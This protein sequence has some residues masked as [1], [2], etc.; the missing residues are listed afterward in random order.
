MGTDEQAASR[1]ILVV[2]TEAVVGEGIGEVLAPRLRGGGREAFVVA[3]AI[4]G[5][6]FEH[7]M[8]SVDDARAEAQR[9]LDESLGALRDEGFEV[10]GAVGDS[11]PVLAIQ[12]ALV[13]FAADEIVIVTRPEDE[14]RWLEA[15]LFE[16][17][18]IQFEQEV[19]H[20]ALAREDGDRA[21]VEDVERAAPGFHEP[22]DREIE[23]ES[24]NLPK[25][26]A[27]DIAG[28]TVAVV[29]SILLVILAGTC[30]P[31]EVQRT[32]GVEGQGTDGGCVA[33]WIIA[34]I[35]VLINLAHIVALFLFQ[36]VRYRGF[37][38]R[39]FAR[40]SL[41]GTPLALAIALLIRIF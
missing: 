14:A 13:T 33:V 20:V 24:R 16:R 17:A 4:I 1:R 10:G 5:S 37:W 11:D 25:L 31:H 30:D 3:P 8:G 2:A 22:P 9:R 23:T 18:R 32:G 41:Y 28:I 36:A 12:D 26:S 7:A 39:F 40:F 6:A 29:G 35:T 34:G 15:D 27:R 19:I 38:N 21:A